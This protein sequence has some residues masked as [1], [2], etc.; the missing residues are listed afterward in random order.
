[1][2]SAAVRISGGSGSAIDQDGV[3]AKDRIY[4]PWEELRRTQA[5]RMER[6]GYRLLH[7]RV[8]QIPGHS[9]PL[10]SDLI[11]R[12]YE[13]MVGEFQD[14]GFIDC[15]ERVA[16]ARA[17]ELFHTDNEERFRAALATM[18][19]PH[20]AATERDEEDHTESERVRLARKALKE[21]DS[22]EHTI[23]I[24]SEVARPVR[25]WEEQRL[26]RA[27][28]TD[29][30]QGRRTDGGAYDWLLEFARS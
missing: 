8:G 23:K 17:S 2:V 4:V 13:E 5:A 16:L 6:A 29:H 27:L 1:M 26:Q 28:T 24:H 19:G 9:F 20:R 11:E 21:I 22:I 3:S 14:R 7:E 15:F 25:L 18:R 12:F 30:E 10:G